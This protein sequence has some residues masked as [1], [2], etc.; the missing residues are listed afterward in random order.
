[1]TEARHIH[2]AIVD[3]VAKREDR[4]AYLAAAR[5]RLDRRQAAG[6][7]R[8]YTAIAWLAILSSCALAAFVKA[9]F[10]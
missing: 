6:G 1:M 8:S 9:A 10:F 4:A 5:K 2:T 3:D 7:P